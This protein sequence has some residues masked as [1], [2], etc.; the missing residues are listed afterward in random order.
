MDIAGSDFGVEIEGGLPLG[1]MKWSYDL[2]L[3]NGFQLNN[4]GT[5]SSVG[6]S[7]TNNG[8]TVTGRLGLLPFSNSC[9]EIGVSGMYGSLATPAGATFSNTDPTNTNGPYI[10]MAGVDFNFVHNYN[11]I[12]L[13]VKAQYSMAAVTKMNYLDTATS[14]NYTFTNTTSTYFAQASIRPSKSNNKVLKNLELAY[15]YVNYTSPKQS[16]WG[17]NYTESDIALDYWLSWR[18]VLKVGYE[19]I[20]SD[21]TTSQVQSSGLDGTSTNINQL[22]I[23]FSTE[24]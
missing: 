16:T 14:S 10:S 19:M 9:M 22:I 5:F 18:T 17:Q 8:K 12:Q 3:S 13:N 1:N 23:Q 4:D 21:G 11:P 2:A 20:K 15:R 7:A 6:I 24:F